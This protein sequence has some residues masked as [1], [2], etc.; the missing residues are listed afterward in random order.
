MRR[1]NRKVQHRA[2]KK[3]TGRNLVQRTFGWE[4]EV[5]R[6]PAMLQEVTSPA[7]EMF[8]VLS[9]H[10]CSYDPP[11]WSSGHSS[12][13]KIQ[14]AGFDSRRYQISWEAV[15]LEQGPRILVSTIEEL[16]GRK[17]SGSGLENPEYGRRD[18]SLWSH[19]TVYPQKL[20][21]TSSTSGG[22]SA[23]IVHSRTQ[24]TEF[25]FFSVVRMSVL[26]CSLTV[27]WY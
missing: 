4:A 12:R 10:G 5:I 14:M 26:V 3:N 24:A 11:L 13:L 22:R 6:L 7:E 18:P 9:D 20:A 19:G 25:F 17:G 16:L 23:G 15:G 27:L 8:A 1:Q 2:Q 21:L